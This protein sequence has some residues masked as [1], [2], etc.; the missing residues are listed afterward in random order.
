MTCSERVKDKP[1]SHHRK[2]SIRNFS[3]RI[4]QFDQVGSDAPEKIAEDEAQC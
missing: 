2:N 4:L 1:V 3:D